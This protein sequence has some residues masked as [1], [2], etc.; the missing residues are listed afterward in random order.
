V[1]RCWLGA[2]LLHG[3]FRQSPGLCLPDGIP[4]GERRSLF[5]D[6]VELPLGFWVLDWASARLTS[7]VAKILVKE[8]LGVHAITSGIGGISVT[9]LYATAGCSDP[10]LYAFEAHGCSLETYARSPHHVSLEIWGISKLVTMRDRLSSIEAVVPRD[11]GT[12][13]Y[14][15]HEGL[16]VFEQE[17]AKAYRERGLALEYFKSWDSRWHDS[18]LLFNSMFEVD[19]AYLQPCSELTLND[20]VEMEN[21]FHHT[22][23]EGGVVRNDEGKV[24]AARCWHDY[25][26]IAPACRANVSK[27]VISLTASPG[28]GLLDNIQRAALFN[29]PMAFAVASNTTAWG[30]SGRAFRGAHYWYVPDD[31]FVDLLPS[32]I[33]FPPYKAEEWAVGLRATQNA[34]TT[35]SKVVW[36]RLG[37]LDPRVERFISNLDFGGTILD[38]LLVDATTNDTDSHETVACRWIL[39]NQHVWSRWIPSPTECNVGLGLVNA[40]RSFVDSL[41]TSGGMMAMGGAVG[42]DFC[43]PGRYSAE[44]E[45]DTRACIQC[46][47]GTSQ[48]APLQAACDACPS[49]KFAAAP[50][51]ESCQPCAVGYFQNSTGASACHACPSPSTTRLYGA[52]EINQCVCPV[53]TY[54]KAG[55]PDRSQIVCESC[56]DRMVCDVDSREVYLFQSAGEE[57]M[58]EALPNAVPAP[59]YPQVMAGYMT[60]AAAPFTVYKCLEEDRC[61]GGRPGTCAFNRDPESIACAECRD[62]TYTSGSDKCEAC[63]GWL[64]ILLLSV[65]PFLLLIG[66]S[67]LSIYANKTRI[68]E[69]SATATGAII[70]GLTVTSIQTI[71]V[72]GG[73]EVQWVEPLRSVLNSL[74][75]VGLDLNAIGVSCLVGHGTGFFI[76]RQILAPMLAVLLLGM[77]LLRK[78][79]W[80]KR[81]NV[82][83]HVCNSVGSL[84]MLF[85][86]SI[87][88]SGI[89][90][91]IC[92]AHPNGVGESMVSY[93]GVM[94]YPRNDSHSS[95]MMAGLLALILVAAPF[96]T[97]VAWATLA[98]PKLVAGSK[99]NNGGALWRFYFLFRRFEPHSYFYGLLLL[100]R[101]VLICL[102]PVAF[103]NNAVAQILVLSGLLST[104]L[105]AQS[106]LRPWRGQ[107]ANYLDTLI[108]LMI[109]LLL[110]C[111]A[112]VADS[113]HT[114]ATISAI[115][116]ILLILIVS[117]VAAGIAYSWYRRLQPFPFYF[118]FVC[119]HKAGAAAQ[120]RL[121][122]M[123][124]QEKSQQSCFI[125]S[126]DLVHLD[127]LFDV[128]RSKVRT[129]IVY[130]TSDV[131]KRPWCAGEVTTAF[132][133]NVKVVRVM[134]PSFI[135]PEEHCLDGPFHN[136]MDAVTNEFLEAGIIESDL[137]AALKW[138][139]SDSVVEVVLNDAISGTAKWSFLAEELCAVK[140]SLSE[141]HSGRVTA[142]ATSIAG[143]VLEVPGLL[144]EGMGIAAHMQSLGADHPAQGA[145]LISSEDTSD[146]SVAI[147]G[148]LAALLHEW[149]M[150]TTN[151][152]VHPLCDAPEV[153]AAHSLSVGSMRRAFDMSRGVIVV[154]TASSLTSRQLRSIIVAEEIISMVPSYAVLSVC[155]PQFVFPAEKFYKEMPVQILEDAGMDPSTA[156]PLVQQFFRRISTRFT[157][158]ASRKIL[159][160][161]VEEIQK[162]VIISGSMTS[163][164]RLISRLKNGVDDKANG[165]R[166]DMMG[167][168]ASGNSFTWRHF[169]TKSG[170]CGG[171]PSNG[172]LDSG[173][174]QALAEAARERDQEEH[175]QSPSSPASP[176]AH[177]SEAARV[178]QREG[179]SASSES[180][181]VVEYDLDTDMPGRGMV[182]YDIGTDA[183]SDGQ[184][185]P[186]LGSGGADFP[187]Y[188]PHSGAVWSTY[189]NI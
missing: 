68:T 56:P 183:V 29:M 153:D 10:L 135:T 169:R 19:T 107:A 164:G 145:I 132:K 130:M 171:S 89:M 35:L 5:V 146:E 101:S 80:H 90:P 113:R 129:L 92:Y 137:S 134:T 39:S 128:V 67:V 25:W 72:L 168:S 8:V 175:Y 57:D 117:V 174:A 66:L 11:G 21:Y 140:G 125:D 100:V 114:K 51:Q 50:G 83:L 186:S 156:C 121:L 44:I 28:W 37:A 23:D 30:Q 120:A 2:V 17:R 94:C 43:T 178:V 181:F 24:A 173:P 62:G 45:G 93:Q 34:M 182:D 110:T 13:G 161:E 124:L 26:W 167:A 155:T 105:F 32:Q 97:V 141:G 98:Y 84:F 158:N 189:L 142:L 42:C 33:F 172:D 170:G 53:G 143:Q 115:G 159:E 152:P 108:N 4:E 73:L 111:G 109:L 47:A 55:F 127:E 87:V 88:L 147:T 63:G 81:L 180:D 22:G 116:H 99:V 106:T 49:G 12:M 126:D 70:A 69:A 150:S 1:V 77:T 151:H 61:P 31:T 165:D 179:S 103:R 139:L 3:V 71:S 38:R 184:G 118:R 58:P 154:L 104:F 14:L 27:C 64:A 76:L 102:V 163:P 60:K 138:V 59:T 54:E 7:E 78:M 9:G 95:M 74:S 48:P 122:Q 149:A 185:S 187:Q 176:S 188:S 91:W 86:I 85:F 162:R 177:E 131:L 40:S 41:A 52:T 75:L 119:H 16:Y 82:C 15:G 144:Q 18:S 46:A 166:S 157:P 36:N 136:Y 112:T 79:I 6:G 96:F 160:T 133:S 65:A 148:I 123:L 20:A